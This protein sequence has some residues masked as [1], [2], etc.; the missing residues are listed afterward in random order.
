MWYNQKA[1][2]VVLRP[3]RQKCLVGVLVLMGAPGWGLQKTFTATCAGRCYKF[4][5]GQSA[6]IPEPQSTQDTVREVVRTGVCKRVSL[7]ECV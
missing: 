7:C 3:V 1:G 6:A 5:R 2:V 4:W